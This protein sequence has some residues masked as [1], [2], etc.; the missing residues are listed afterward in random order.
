[1][2]HL[3]NS[4]AFPQKAKHRSDHMTQQAYSLVKYPEEIKTN[5]T[6]KVCTWIYIAALFITAEKWKKN[7]SYQPVDE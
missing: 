2:M 6:K 1:M 4:L 7:P 5:I 3:E